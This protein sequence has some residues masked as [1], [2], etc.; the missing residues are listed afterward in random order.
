MNK[1]HPDFEGLSFVLLALSTDKIRETWQHLFVSETG[2][3]VCTDGHRCH[4]YTPITDDYKPGFYRV[5]KVSKTEITTAP[6]DSNLSPLANYEL[7]FPKIKTQIE[8]VSDNVSCRFAQVIREMP[9][10]AVDFLLFKDAATG[11]TS[12]QPGKGRDPVLLI[13]GRRSAVVSPL[14]C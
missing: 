12:F 13:G 9:C 11:M 4:R 10:N 7:I 1:H 3:M 14:R 6:A 5:V 8:F 2:E